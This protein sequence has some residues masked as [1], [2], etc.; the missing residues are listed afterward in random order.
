VEAGSARGEL[1]NNAQF[2][3]LDEVTL[4]AGPQPVEIRYSPRGLPHPGTG[5]YPLSL[6][7]VMLTPAGYEDTLTS[8]PA[9]QYRQFCDQRLDWV[10]ALR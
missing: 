6:G 9:S 10:A 1:N 3:F 8:L 5:A 7:P 4:G 2:I